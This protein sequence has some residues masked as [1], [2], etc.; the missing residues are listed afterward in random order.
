MFKNFVMSNISW[1]VCCTGNNSILTTSFVVVFSFFFATTR[2]GIEAITKIAPILENKQ[3][4][5]F[6]LNMVSRS[7]GSYNMKHLCGH[8]GATTVGLVLSSDHTC[9]P[10]SF[11]WV[12]VAGGGVRGGGRGNAANHIRSR[13][14]LSHGHI[15]PDEHK[16]TCVHMPAAIAVLQQRGAFAR[17]TQAALIEFKCNIKWVTNGQSDSGWEQNPSWVGV[18]HNFMSGSSSCSI[19]TCIQPRVSE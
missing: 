13:G 7:I 10:Y 9:N 4:K 19:Y 17:A 16:I 14:T 3:W 15:S 18:I 11:V 6:I 8:N 1:F 5:M 2:K 12:I